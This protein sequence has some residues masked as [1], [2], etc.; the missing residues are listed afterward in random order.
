MGWRQNAAINIRF[1]K[2]LMLKM[3][4]KVPPYNFTF[5]QFAT[6]NH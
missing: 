2:L 4:A 3:A 6:M 5:Y 1:G